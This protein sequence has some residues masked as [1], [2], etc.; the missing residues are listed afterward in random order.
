MHNNNFIN[1]KILGYKKE[2]IR[3]T[4]SAI[5]RFTTTDAILKNFKVIE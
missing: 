3:Y 2:T 5:S 4:Q 1:E